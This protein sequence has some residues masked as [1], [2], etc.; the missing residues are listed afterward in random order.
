M[1]TD[2]GTSPTVAPPPTGIWLRT[3]A[4]G[5]LSFVAFV[6]C[7]M[8]LLW[9]ISALESAVGMPHAAA[10]GTWALGW[11]VIGG[12]LALVCARL[13]FGTWLAVR[14]GGWLVLVVGAL[15][16]G[17]HLGVLADWMIARFGASDPDYVGA[18]F[19]LF[20]VVAGVAVTGLGVQVAP[21]SAVWMP[22]LGVWAGAVL[23]A[24]VLLMNLA[25][26]AGGLAADS[27]LL[28]AVTL[29]AAVYIG[30]VGVLSLARLRR[31]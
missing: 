9:P 18:T 26:L 1:H 29:A 7:F 25:G 15:V 8:S 24:I 16:S 27:K 23:A 14:A 31:D 2:L 11:T 13:V 5:T 20:A 19:G 6:A 12:L 3:V 28:A 30:A 21:R 17:A 4:W 22:V 10:L